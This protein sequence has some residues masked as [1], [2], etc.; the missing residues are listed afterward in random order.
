VLPEEAARI[1]RAAS[2]SNR[3]W[4]LFS[5]LEGTRAGE[6]LD[7]DWKDCWVDA[8]WAVVRDTKRNQEDRGIALHPQIVE[9]LCRVPEKE[10]VG[11]VF[12]TSRGKP[13]AEAEG[14]RGYKTGWKATKR[15]AGISRDLHVHDLRHT[16]GTLALTRMPAR[17]IEQQMG[18]A[19]PEHEMHRRYVHVPQPELIQAVA[20]LPWLDCPEQTYLEWA[21]S[22]FGRCE[23][24]PVPLEEAVEPEQPAAIRLRVR[25]GKGVRGP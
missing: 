3:R 17:M 16:F 19:D 6:T 4:Y 13:Y 11:K 15:R 18:H 21:Q 24:P 7:L 25:R 12:K 20:K 5:M 8:A 2:P 23:V 14:G 1:L 10:R 9:M 22:G